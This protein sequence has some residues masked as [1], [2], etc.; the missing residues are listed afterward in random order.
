MKQLDVL[1]A[2]NLVV[3]RREGRQRW[4]YLNPLP[5]Q[6]VCDR[7]VSRHVNRLASSLSQLKEHVEE[8][9]RNEVDV[10]DVKSRKSKRGA[11]K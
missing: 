8:R 7:W 4:N 5:I 9:H 1:V 3:I 6:N 10:A 2:A 11:S